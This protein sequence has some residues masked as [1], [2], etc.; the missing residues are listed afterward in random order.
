MG[1]RAEIKGDEELKK[2]I[3]GLRKDISAIL[4]Q[5]AGAG[6]NVI[7]DEANHLAPGPHIET[8]IVESTW[9]HSDINI[10]PDKEHWYYQFFE[11]GVQPHEITPSKVGGLAFPGREGEMVVRV[12]ASHQGMGAK[13]FL[14]PA[15]DTKKGDA[16]EA[17]G[18][19]F[20]QVINKYIER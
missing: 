11:T 4:D 6:A 10:G 1:F 7:A 3:I 15:H 14:R 19:K 5:A 8:E 17:T 12:F 16:E 13:P 20:L 18:R 9:T 2:K